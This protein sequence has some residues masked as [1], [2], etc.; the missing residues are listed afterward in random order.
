MQT[1]SQ[2]IQMSST[3]LASGNSFCTESEANPLWSVPDHSGESYI[4]V[5]QRIHRFFVPKSYF[6]IGVLNGTTL[7][8]ASCFSIGIDPDFKI[9]S[10]S[11][12]NKPACCLF[13]MSS[14]SFFKSFDPVK[15]IGHA[16]DVAF[17]D[18]MHW[19]EFLLRDFI[20]V[21]KSCKAN[22]LI[23]IHDCIPTDEYVGRRDMSDRRLKER[24]SHP[25]WWAG[26]VW[27][28]IAI[29][30]KYRPDLH[31]VAFNAPPTG[32]IAI[33]CLNPCS[34]VLSDRYFDLVDEYKSHTLSGHG[35]VYLNSLKIIDTRQ[36]VSFAT[37]STQFWL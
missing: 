31:I 30:M 24:S 23:F 12:I 20:N 25:V 15:I 35:S 6:E 29:L 8:L 19:F 18:G 27:K 22:S 36:Y 10:P 4:T 16:I 2:G 28:T 7:E 26:D 17:L 33:T 37:L 9:E 21:E 1:F 34:T 3:L 32:L 14:D 11:L 5:L 13:R